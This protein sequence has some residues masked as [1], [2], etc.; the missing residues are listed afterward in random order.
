[1]LDQE[2]ADL[3]SQITQAYR[4]VAGVKPQAKT[5]ELLVHTFEQE[6]KYFSENVE[7]A[8]KLLSTGESKRD[9]SL[10]PAAHAAM[11]ILTG[12]IMNLDESL[13]RG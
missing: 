10:E 8:N 13:T 2:L 1:M 7:A 12:I 4:L 3:R 11:T 6:K 5:L 9:A